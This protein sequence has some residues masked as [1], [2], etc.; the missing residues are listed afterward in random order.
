[1]RWNPIRAYRRVLRRM[2]SS[3]VG[4]PEEL[5]TRSAPAVFLRLPKEMSR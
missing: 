4:T 1:M 2:V 5:P 3:N